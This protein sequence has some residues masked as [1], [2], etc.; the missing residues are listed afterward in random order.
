[1]KPKGFVAYLDGLTSLAGIPSLKVVDLSY[2]C[3]KTPN[4]D[5][6]FEV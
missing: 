6:V 4:W 3:H 1:M 5:Q 2:R